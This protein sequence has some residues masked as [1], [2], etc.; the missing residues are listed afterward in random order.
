MQ[1]LTSYYY[2]ATPISYKGDEIS[3]LSRLVFLDLMRDRQTDRRQ[4][5]ATTVTEGCYTYSVRA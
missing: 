1:N 3:R 5:D 4:T 2:S